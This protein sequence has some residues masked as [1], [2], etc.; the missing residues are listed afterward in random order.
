MDRLRKA[1]R[2]VAQARALISSHVHEAPRP[3]TSELV[4]ALDYCDCVS[5]ACG[6]YELH[7]EEVSVGRIVVS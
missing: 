3:S 7:T 2:L 1:M 6:M 5:T 4:D